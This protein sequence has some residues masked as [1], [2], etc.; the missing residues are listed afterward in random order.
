MAVLIAVLGTA[1][2][3]VANLMG[4]RVSKD[5]GFGCTV[6]NGYLHQFANGS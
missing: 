1:T 6:R 3:H 5:T 4:L 2:V